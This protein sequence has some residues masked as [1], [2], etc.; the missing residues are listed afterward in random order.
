MSCNSLT[1]NS[2]VGLGPAQVCTTTLANMT[3]CVKRVA[4]IF[5]QWTFIFME[6][7]TLDGDP[8]AYALGNFKWQVWG[9]YD[10]SGLKASGNAN[11]LGHCGLDLESI[12][13]SSFQVQE[14]IG[15][16]ATNATQAIVNAVDN[17]DFNLTLAFIMRWK[18]GSC[19]LDAVR[20]ETHL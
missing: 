19:D 12:A 18:L 3:A 1:P 6:D 13:L 16:W 20:M 8:R 15:G 4:Y 9:A 10:S 2:G 7:L 14:M 11:C 17:N 5:P